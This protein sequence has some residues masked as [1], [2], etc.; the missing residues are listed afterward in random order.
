MKADII[1]RVNNLNNDFEYLFSVWNQYKIKNNILSNAD[2]LVL[3]KII[4]FLNEKNEQF[5]ILVEKM[6][7]IEYVLK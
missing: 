3:P 4:D 1:V 2:N 7:K 5:A 6:H